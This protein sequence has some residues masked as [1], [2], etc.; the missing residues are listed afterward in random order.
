[1]VSGKEDGTLEV[2]HE[3]LLRNWPLLKSWLDES[4][5][6]LLWR[7]R[8]QAAYSEFER[9]GTLLR[10]APLVEVEAERWMVERPRDLSPDQAAFIR[11][12]LAM[13]EQERIASERRRRRIIS[14]LGIGLVI[15]LVL[16]LLAGWQWQ[17]AKAQRRTAL[18]RQLAA[19]A[20]SLSSQG[21]LDIA[22]LL[23]HEALKVSETTEARSALL[24]ALQFGEPHKGPGDVRVSG[25]AF[26]NHPDGGMLVLGGD[27]GSVIL[28][29]TQ[30]RQQIGEPLKGPGDVGVTSMA[31]S[32]DGGILAL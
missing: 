6:L 26:S 9:S 14:G 10:G 31:F 11:E 21:L 25:I 18:S 12:S 29:D 17:E 28:W 24:T 22:L 7:Q 1:L 30:R 16:L 2:A 23:S 4:R 20:I 13:R 32:R 15:A 8:L 27:D 5:E 19:Q 3:T